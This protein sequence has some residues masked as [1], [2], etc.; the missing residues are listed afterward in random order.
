MEST[1]R[2][3]TVDIQQMHGDVGEF[4]CPEC[5][6][7]ISPSDKTDDIYTLLDVIMAP[8]SDVKEILLKC[9]CGAVIKLIGL[10]EDHA[11]NN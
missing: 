6:A 2:V 3:Y 9:K 8:D 4:P 1:S 11:Q 10:Q 7:E 5:G